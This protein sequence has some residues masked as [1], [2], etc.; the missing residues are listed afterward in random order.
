MCIPIWKTRCGSGWLRVREQ[1][2]HHMPKAPTRSAQEDA[3]PAKQEVTA[4]SRGSLSS[5]VLSFGE[6]LATLLL[7]VILIIIIVNNS[8]KMPGK[9]QK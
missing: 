7:P 3:A 5:L 4:P 1:K 6:V 2:L 9:P 8:G